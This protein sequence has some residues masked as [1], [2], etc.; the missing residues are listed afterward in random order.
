MSRTNTEA[1]VFLLISGIVTACAPPA[2]P[3]R[4]AAPPP[5]PL[6]HGVFAREGAARVTEASFFAKLG[7]RRY[8]L[9]GEK[10][11]NV[12][13]HAFEAQVVAAVGARGPRPVVMEHFREKAQPALDAFGQVQ[14]NETSRLPSLV[15]WD[16]GWGPFAPFEPIFAA[17]LAH[18]M[19]IVAGSFDRID[20]RL[21]K[22]HPEQAIPAPIAARISAVTFDDAQEKSL[23]DELFAAHCGHLPGDFLAPMAMVQHARDALFATKMQAGEGG[24]VLLAGKG[25][26]RGDRGVP[27]F[28]PLGSFVSIALVEVDPARTRPAEYEELATHDYVYFATPAPADEDPCEAFRHPKAKAAR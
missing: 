21:L 12:E 2:P 23:V 9:V 10:H 8:V 28:L 15:G 25:H 5:H 17:A 11:D 3:A 20:V 4:P 24:A 26:T 14:K 16:E 18:R 1:W 22:A 27:R 13:H 6:L 19:P 7:E